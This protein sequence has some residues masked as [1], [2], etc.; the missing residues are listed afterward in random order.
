MDKKYFIEQ[1]LSLVDKNVYLCKQII[2]HNNNNHATASV[3]C[4]YRGRC[5]F[6]NRD[7]DTS[8][9][10]R[11]QKNAFDT[12]IDYVETRNSFYVGKAI[13]HNVVQF[14]VKAA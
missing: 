5:Q 1:L 14:D 11:V 3:T 6:E 9:I 2:V 7:V 10:E 4:S 12:G 8:S 13:F